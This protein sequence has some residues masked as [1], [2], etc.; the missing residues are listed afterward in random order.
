MDHKDHKSDTNNSITHTEYSIHTVH[1]IEQNNRLC[2]QIFFIILIL[3]NSLIG[4]IVI[5]QYKP[6][7][8]DK[9]KSEFPKIETLNLFLYIYTLILIVCATF[10]IVVST[11]IVILLKLYKYS[12]KDRYLRYIGECMNL[13]E[14]EYNFV[15][16]CVVI[17]MFLILVLYLACIPMGINLIVRL[18]QNNTFK[19]LNKFYLLYF[20]ITNN[21]IV[22]LMMV[23]VVIY[24]LFFVNIKF[25]NR[26]PIILDEEFIEKI[27]KEVEDAYK[28][29]GSLGFQNSNQLRDNYNMSNKQNI[30]TISEKKGDIASESTGKETKIIYLEN[31]I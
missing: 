5:S 11:Y 20:F 16:F 31:R 26:K 13:D 29:S 28:L 12:N 9:T 25:S 19:N 4:F 18:L 7:L 6:F 8:V 15:H 21:V 10:S 17:F 2:L 1:E 3:I 30:Y 23:G 22:G 24:G 27:E 14:E